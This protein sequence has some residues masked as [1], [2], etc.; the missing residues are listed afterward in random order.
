[1]INSFDE[2]IG[3]TLLVGLTHVDENGSV[4]AVAY[5]RINVGG[6]RADCL[7]RIY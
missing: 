6:G 2:L 7:Y 3:K 1:M 4:Y 5:V